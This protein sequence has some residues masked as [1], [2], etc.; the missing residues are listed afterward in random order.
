MISMKIADSVMLSNNALIKPHILHVRLRHFTRNQ[1]LRI[2]QMSNLHKKIFMYG[3]GFM[4][5]HELTH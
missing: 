3:I 5:C 4:R 1:L 2:I